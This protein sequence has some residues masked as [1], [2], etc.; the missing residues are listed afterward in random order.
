MINARE[1]HAA[2]LL[3]NGQVLIT[4]GDNPPTGSLNSAELYDPSSSTFVAVPSFL[5]TPR[6]SHDMTLLNGGKILITGGATDGSTNST[7]LNT[8]EL[9]DP[10]SQSFTSIDD[11]TSVREHQTVTLLNDGTALVTGGTDGSNIFDSAELY[12]SS[13]LNGLTSISVTP[14]APSI[15][16][17][18]QQRFT[19]VG[20]FSDGSSEN[21]ASALWTSSALNVAAV[22]GDT[23]NPGVVASAAQGTATI[24]A[25]AAGASGL[26]TLTVTVPTLVSITLSPS[27]DTL[28]LGAT[29][30]FTATGVYSDGS[31]QDLTSIATWSSSASVVT[32]INSSGVAAGLFQGTATI[33]ASFGSVNA[34]TTLTVAA[35]A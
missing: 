16:A 2:I 15:G 10:V 6:I 14:V 35:T 12:V 28:P 3:D 32:E 7:P 26:A 13:H 4:G 22:S 29:Q 8:A 27:E 1:G 18:L 9:Y 24:T 20:T 17:G 23:T 34:S 11:M 30:Q 19:A 33:Q 25:S 31:T 5:T 21:L